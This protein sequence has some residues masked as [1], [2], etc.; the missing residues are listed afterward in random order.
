MP[1]AAFAGVPLAPA[2]NDL[3]A[4]I[5]TLQATPATPVALPPWAPMVPAT[6]VPWLL[7]S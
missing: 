1:S 2:L 5:C 4:S 3:T 6:W 7:S